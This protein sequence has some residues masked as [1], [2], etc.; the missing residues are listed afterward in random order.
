MNAHGTGGG[1]Y[2]YFSVGGT[3]E[4]PPTESQEVL[5][6]WSWDD[7]GGRA[8]RYPGSVPADYRPSRS[9]GKQSRQWYTDGPS[10]GVPRLGIGPGRELLLLGDDERSTALAMRWAEMFD[11]VEAAYRHS[12]PDLTAAQRH[13]AI[14]V[15]RIGRCTIRSVPVD[16]DRHGWSPLLLAGHA[17]PSRMGG[18]YYVDPFESSRSRRRT[19]EVQRFLRLLDGPADCGGHRLELSMIPAPREENFYPPYFLVWSD[20]DLRPL[21]FL[22]LE[23]TPRTPAVRTLARYPGTAREEINIASWPTPGARGVDLCRAPFMETLCLKDLR[24]R[25][26]LATAATSDPAVAGPLTAGC[27]E[28]FARL[29]TLPSPDPCSDP[30]A[31]RSSVGAYRTGYTGELVLRERPR[32]ASRVDPSGDVQWLWA[33]AQVPDRVTDFHLAD[34]TGIALGLPRS[35]P[36]RPPSRQSTDVPRI[37]P[38]ATSTTATPAATTASAADRPVTTQPPPS[39]PTIESPPPSTAIDPPPAG[40]ATEPSPPPTGPRPRTSSTAAEPTTRPAD[41]ISRPPGTAVEPAT[42]PEPGTRPPTSSPSSTPGPGTTIEPGATIE[43]ATTAEPGTAVGPATTA[44]P[45]AAIGPAA[46]EP[47][48]AIAQ[49]T[50]TGPASPSTDVATSPPPAAESTNRFGIGSPAAWPQSLLWPLALAILAM[51][52]GVALLL[53]GHRISARTRRHALASGQVAEQPELLLAEDDHG[54]RLLARGDSG[55][56]LQRDF[57]PSFPGDSDPPA[58]ELLLAPVPTPIDSADPT[59][60]AAPANESE[61]PAPEPQTLKPAGDE[62][63]ADESQSGTPE[64]ELLEA[65]P[66]EPAPAAVLPL[67]P[68]E[69]AE[70]PASA[71]GADLRGGRLASEWHAL[72]NHERQGIDQSLTAISRL[73]DWIGCLLPVLDEIDHGRGGLPAL[74][75][76]PPPAQREW[77][78]STR[79]LREFT[80]FDLT[81]LHQLRRELADP[82]APPASNGGGAEA[83]YHSGAGLLD[84]DLGTL[85]E[86]LRRHLLRPGSGRVQEVV[87]ALQYL[88]EAMPIEHMEKAERKAYLGAV[89]ERLQEKGLSTKFHQLVGAL[90]SGLGLRYREVRCYKARIAQTGFEFLDEA[91]DSISLSDRVGYPVGTEDR[92]V[93][94][95]SELFLF[96]AATGSRYSGQASLDSGA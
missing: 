75:R 10:T 83:Q 40:L 62:T 95:A 21:D 23:P 29:G 25:E 12:S 57:H 71:T 93:V 2:V 26:Q 86:R 4:T 76:L 20:L 43:P 38:P 63:P 51:I 14:E 32:L 59:G 41:T 17:R 66:A 77:R 33:D 54:E 90:A 49:E 1:D 79:V 96:D 5:L 53:R 18:F 8:E 60:D 46:A 55:P 89:R 16:G 11:S 50:A 27:R 47:G 92:T 73:G 30:R 56:S 35:A 45:G 34:G 22:D 74:D 13:G 67:E 84:P 80:D 72:E 36:P 69:L 68:P 7:F 44:E 19:V 3:A 65:P 52:V 28:F 31:W 58:D 78:D 81:V 61:S 91:H 87:S 85:P 15:G 6:G 94:R 88:I 48:T 82:D 70:T 64:P 37:A 42:T 39:R 24:I 9:T